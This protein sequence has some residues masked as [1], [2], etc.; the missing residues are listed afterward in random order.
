MTARHLKLT[1]ATESP[2]SFRLLVSGPFSVSQDGAC[3]RPS[4]PDPG[5]GQACEEPAAG[6]QLLL[7][8]PLESM[9]VRAGSAVLALH[10]H[11]PLAPGA[12]LSHS[13][14]CRDHTLHTSLTVVSSAPVQ[15]EPH[16]SVRAHASPLTP[17]PSAFPRP[18]ARSRP[19][20]A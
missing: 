13:R 8:R 19:G 11:G 18:V 4:G 16:V 10:G 15:A 20:V 17:D 3:P 14:V 7:L 6:T 9:L 1:N 5:W 12:V 2:L